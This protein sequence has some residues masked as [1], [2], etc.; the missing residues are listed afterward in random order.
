MKNLFIILIVAVLISSCTT[1]KP[2]IIYKVP[3]IPEIS[4]DQKK[5][6][7]SDHKS[8][9]AVILDKQ[10]YI[11]HCY[12]SY[13]E[14]KT[15]DYTSY[16]IINPNSE[17]YTTFKAVSHPSNKI[18]NINLRVFYPNNEY[19]EYTLSDCHS[20][21][22]SS[23]ETTYKIAYPNI[24][25][26]CIIQE[27]IEYSKY[28]NSQFHTIPLQFNIPTLNYD[29]VFKYPT[30]WISQ[31]KQN[32]VSKNNVKTSS[33]SL[34]KRSMI[35]Y[36][37]K[38]LP[39]FK[40]ESY[41]P[42]L[43]EMDQYLEIHLKKITINN[44]ASPI[45]FDAPKNWHDLFDDFADYCL[46]DQSFFGNKSLKT[47]K[48]I[49]KNCTTAYE[50]ADSI[51]T[52]VQNNFIVADHL[53]NVTYNSLISSK[54]GDP[55]KITGL[56]NRLLKEAEIESQ[57]VICHS[58]ND[59]TFDPDYI[60]YTQF[61]DPGILITIDSTNYIVFPWNKYNH[62]SYVPSKYIGQK[63]L[64]L[65]K[66]FVYKSY[67]SENTS[68]LGQII[69]LPQDSIDPIR[70]KEDY[71][72]IVDSEGMITVNETMEFNKDIA[73]A[74]RANLSESNK[75]EIDKYIR[76]VLTFYD[77]NINLISYRF[78]NLKNNHLPLK[79]IIQYSIDNLVSVMPDEVI[80]QTNG[81]LSPASISTYKI[82]TDE[83]QN[84]I[85]VDQKFEYI[86]NI[87]IS[88]PENWKFNNKLS[89]HFVEND[90]GFYKSTNTVENNK[91]IIAQTR[92]FNKIKKDKSFYNQLLDISGEEYQ[93][94][95]PS[96]IFE[97]QE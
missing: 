40:N 76:K 93:S 21:T 18:L 2:T 39:G 80:F 16:L 66:P 3:T 1:Y 24:T 4:E 96:L 86:K 88:Y 82:K 34:S 15:I 19:L 49:T 11:E 51:V 56:T 59:G 94:M 8:Y 72:I 90:F 31:I 79:L 47:A 44:M 43:E 75:E 70:I 33:D 10:F 32:E 64:I 74:Y 87:S 45:Y 5:Q 69:D 54:K 95:I 68:K 7:L 73:S 92:S 55:L 65:D 30:E 61:T 36:S 22:N 84:P 97:I 13:W 37:A 29:F 63:A 52:Y 27:S 25:Q 77:A 91:I 58:I 6:L 14:K 78:E 20:E 81:L 85:S 57:V 50:K 28:Y 23:N 17:R 83:R 35:T 26:G 60:S 42:S 89:N 46:S 38:N 12:P 67:Q 41:A 53:T 62:I 48:E 9:D 71:D